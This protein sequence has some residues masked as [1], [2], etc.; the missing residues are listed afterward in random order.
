MKCRECEGELEVARS[1][2]R[3]RM[4]CTKCRMEYQIH[5]VAADLDDKTSAILE[6]YTAIIYD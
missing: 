6:K 5:E 4:R 1:C 2:R 3:I